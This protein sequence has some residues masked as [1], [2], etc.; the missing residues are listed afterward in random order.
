MNFRREAR[1]IL[2]VGLVP[3]ALILWALVLPWIR[4][5]KL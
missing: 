1:S 5:L 4:H 2:I 3:A